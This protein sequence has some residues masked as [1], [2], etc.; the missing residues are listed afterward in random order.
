MRKKS[1]YILI[2]IERC[3]RSYNAWLGIH[4]HERLPQGDRDD[5]DQGQCLRESRSHHG[6]I[7]KW[8]EQRDRQHHWV[9]TLHGFGGDG[10]IKD[11]IS[12]LIPI[13]HSFFPLLM[14]KTFILPSSSFFFFCFSKFILE[15]KPLK[16]YSSTN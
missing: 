7:L 4:V 12:P 5:N 16:S 13:T 6:P 14:L 10:T 11:P 1:L 2:V 9:V 3:T 8:L 15:S